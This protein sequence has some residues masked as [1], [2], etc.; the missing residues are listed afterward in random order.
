MNDRTGSTDAEA[1][2][3]ETH[4]AALLI[5]SMPADHLTVIDVI[6]EKEVSLKSVVQILRKKEEELTLKASA[7][8]RGTALEAQRNRACYKCGKT[9]HRWRR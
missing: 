9:D 4:L 5:G 1:T 6:N 8:T 2:W 3:K 7:R